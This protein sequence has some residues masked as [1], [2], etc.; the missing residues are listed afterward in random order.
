VVSI[1]TNDGTVVPS[2]NTVTVAT[3]TKSAAFSLTVYAASTI[4]TATVTAALN[5][6]T[7]TLNITLSPSVSAKAGL[8]VSSTN[9]AFGPVASGVLAKVPVTVTSSGTA[10]VVVSSIS[11][12]GSLFHATGVGLPLTLNP[13]QTANLTLTFSPPYATSYNF[14][15]TVTIASNAGTSAINMTGSGAT[16]ATQHQVGLSWQEPNSTDPIANYNVYRSV[17]GGSFSKVTTVSGMSYTDVSVSSGTSYRYYVTA[18]DTSGKE[19][20]PS[21]TTSAVVPTS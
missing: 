15:G 18:V 5:G 20:V 16:A 12:A 6:A 8:T 4:K 14:T 1:S 11:V 17:S 13:G 10:A 3:G 21:N 19:G 2:S 7:K 9:V